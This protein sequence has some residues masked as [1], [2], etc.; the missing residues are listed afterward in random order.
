ME[1]FQINHY[2]KNHPNKRSSTP[3]HTKT[4]TTKHY[5]YH[6]QVI[7]MPIYSYIEVPTDQTKPPTKPNP[8]KLA[9]TPVQNN[10]PKA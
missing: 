10:Q 2:P 3:T 5:N 9:G 4:H 1:Y 6:Y 8:N 7:P